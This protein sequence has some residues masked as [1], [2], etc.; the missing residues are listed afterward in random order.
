[1][2]LFR[3]HYRGF[4]YWVSIAAESRCFVPTADDLVR[5]SSSVMYCRHGERPAQGGADAVAPGEGGAAAGGAQTERD[6]G[7]LRGPAGDH[8][9]GEPQTQGAGTGKAAKL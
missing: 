7:V 3:R 1:V 5:I 2:E 8:R 9:D 6:G 4:K